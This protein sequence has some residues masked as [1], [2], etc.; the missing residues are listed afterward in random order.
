MRVRGTNQTEC[1]HV[2]LGAHHTLEL[3][4]QRPFTLWKSKW[5]GLDV[6]RIATACNPQ[7]S[8]DLAALLITV[9][10]SQCDV[11]HV[12]HAQLEAQLFPPCVHV[13]RCLL[14]LEQGVRSQALNNT[15]RCRKQAG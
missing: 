5:D 12:T 10:N 9:S 6:D 8:A 15:A 4:P 1:E 3:E 13:V 7:A 2:K 14:S 11:C